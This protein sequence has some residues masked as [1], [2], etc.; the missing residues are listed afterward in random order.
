MVWKFLKAVRASSEPFI[1]QSVGEI[2]V[3]LLFASRATLRIRTSEG[4]T[5]TIIRVALPTMND[6]S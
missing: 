5:L 3:M 1:A 2:N 6:G 4:H